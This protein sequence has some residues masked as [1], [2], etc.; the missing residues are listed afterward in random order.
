MPINIRLEYVDIVKDPIWEEVPLTQVEWRIIH[1]KGFA[2]LRHIRQMGFAYLAFPGANHT[3]YEHSIGAMRAA[4]LLYQMFS[5]IPIEM[6][7]ALAIR[8]LRI[9][10]L[11]H[12]VGHPPFSHAV[13]ETF[14]KYPHLL[15]FEND[16]GK[17]IRALRRILGDPPQYAHEQF[18]SFVIETNG[19]IRDLITAQALDI[20][21]IKML[22]SGKAVGP[23]L[24]PLNSLLDGDF[25]ADKI[26]YIIRDSYYCGLSH[27]IDL[28]EFRGRLV[29]ERAEGEHAFK[30]FMF[31]EGV[32]AIDSLL[33]AR[34]K[35]IKEVHNNE[36]NRIATQMLIEKIRLWLEELS[37]DDRAKMI[38]EM[39]TKLTDYNLISVLAEYREGPDIY[40]ILDGNLYETALVFPF[41]K[42]HPIVKAS[43]H[44]VLNNPISIASIQD[45]LRD[46]F[47]SD[48]LLID[49]REPKPPK[50]TTLIRFEEMKKGKKTPASRN[51][52]DRYYTPHG[53]LIDSFNDLAV[54]IYSP[55]SENVSLSSDKWRGVVGETQ[56]IPQFY[57]KYLESDQSV[58]ARRIVLSAREVRGQKSKS[59][60]IIDIDLLMLVL[61]AIEEYGRDIL[62]RR[63]LWVYSDS[64]LQSYLR[65]VIEFCTK[66]ALQ[67]ES[68]F[69]WDN[70]QFSTKVFRDLERLINM[71]LVD[72]IHKPVPHPTNWGFRVDRR[73]SGWGKG[74]VSTEIGD[75]HHTVYRYV[76]TT[77]KKAKNELQNILKMEEE[78]TSYDK[79]DNISKREPLNKEID[80]IRTRLRSSR[81]IILT[82]G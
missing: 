45:R 43:T 81:D 18:S 82:I 50:F 49:I 53:I 60:I 34:Y 23:G 1:T 72:H 59:G 42:M 41:A 54:Y 3:R 20:D 47:H 68:T 77:L 13:E 78:C 25:D 70:Q 33:L 73:I 29:V 19:E 16:R 15:D 74:Y 76:Q 56:T 57:F 37:S 80:K 69:I 36:I 14:R 62:S 66:K 38:L 44:L 31:P 21:Q 79:M 58:I 32:S 40:D 24:S 4:Y 63:E 8:S 51:I 71:G 48:S 75:L 30:L 26:D 55:T 52:F 9:A 64:V 22:A 10:V 7:P 27:K 46:D 12:D 39:H 65:N 28:N 11:L 17:N 67:I 35:L 2:R 6:D 5:S 61:S